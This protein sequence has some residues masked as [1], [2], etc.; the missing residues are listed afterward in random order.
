MIRGAAVIVLPFLSQKLAI[1]AKGVTL[2]SAKD[3]GDGI[4]VSISKNATVEVLLLR[5]FLKWNMLL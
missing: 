5:D 4:A 2:C 1:I 3:V